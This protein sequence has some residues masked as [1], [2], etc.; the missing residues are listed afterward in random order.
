MA[1]YAPVASLPIYKRLAAAGELGKYHLLIATEVNKDRL[2][3]DDFWK[4]LLY[5]AAE[6]V[7]ASCI[8]LPDALGDMH[9][10]L[11]LV[12]ASIKAFEQSLIPLMGV[13]QGTSWGDIQKLLLEYSKMGIRYLSVPR[14]MTEIHGSRVGLVKGVADYW[15][16]LT[17]GTLQPKKF[18]HLLGFSNNVEDDIRASGWEEVM[19]IDSAMP[20]WYALDQDEYLPKEPPRSSHAFDPG[21]RPEN[22]WEL[23]PNPQSAN[24]DIVLAN[25]GKVRAWLTDAPV[26]LT[27]QLQ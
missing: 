5:A 24:F 13:V 11:K 23:L 2:A 12:R 26:A 20:I 14:V 27:P 17:A 10:T 25:I 18:I 16:D 3:W 19:G 15:K 6:A 22:Y 1:E 4:G 21:K 9:M 8:V 7:D